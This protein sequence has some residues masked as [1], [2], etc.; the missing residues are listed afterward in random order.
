MDRYN[1]RFKLLYRLLDENGIEW[2]SDEVRSFAIA[3]PSYEVSEAQASAMRRSLSRMDRQVAPQLDTQSV[4]WSDLVTEPKSFE[5]CIQ[6]LLKRIENLTT[7]LESSVT[8]AMEL[9]ISNLQLGPEASGQADLMETVRQMGA[10]S[11]TIREM[12]ETDL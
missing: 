12:M 11:S 5:E 6:Y 7:Y 3:P 1:H 9:G 2:L 4:I 8:L 10:I